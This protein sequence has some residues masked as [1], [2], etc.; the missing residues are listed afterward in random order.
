[1]RITFVL[2]APIRI[3]MGGAKV[4]YRYAEELAA[5][6]HE[7]AV[8][9]P[10]RSGGGLGARAFAAVV[11]VRDRLHGV[12]PEPYYA[13]AGARTLVV[14]TPA[15]R[16]V[17]DADVVVATGWQTA[18]WV[19]A[20]P[21]R[22]GA[23]AYFVQNLEDY[24]SPEAPA[25]W[26]LPLATFTCARW[27][28]RAVE[29]AGHETLGHVPNAIDPAEFFVEAPGVEREPL[30]LFLYHRL[31]IKGAEDAVAAL[32]AVREAR[33]DLRAVAFSARPPSHR[34]PEW[35]EV[36]VRPGLSDLRALYNRAAVFLHPSHREGWPLPPME[37][38]A[39]GAAVVAAANEGVQE[40]FD[41]STA[42]IVA[43]GE[44][45]RL[46]EAVLGLLD[47]PDERAA[48]AEAGRQRVAGLS[49][50]ASADRLEAVL[51]RVAAA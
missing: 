1:M 49:W 23:K 28:A 35:V 44:P 2:P 30:V 18:P 51:A 13:A 48:L 34:L 38:A 19:A 45:A 26:A 31:P 20:L 15:P 43:V 40:C 32:S 3:P 37:A 47:R 4:V 27:L 16:H 24:L 6:G 42:R 12:P 11:A 46:A 36:R 39:C 9:A 29:A 33:P 14:P 8:L 41:A 21:A 10:E 17:P 25:T 22:A 50:A 5:R 7:A